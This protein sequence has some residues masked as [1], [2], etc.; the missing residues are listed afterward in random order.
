MSVELR[1]ISSPH[2]LSFSFYKSK[3]RC[4]VF[5]PSKIWWKRRVFKELC[6]Q[7]ESCSVVFGSLW[8]HGLY[9][10]WNSPGQNAGMCSC[11]L[12]QGIFPTQGL[13]PGLPHCGWILYQLSHQE[14]PRNCVKMEHI[15]QAEADDISV[16]C[17]Y[18]EMDFKRRDGS[19][20]A[21]ILKLV[22]DWK[23]YH[24]YIK[25]IW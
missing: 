12:L 18:S 23:L 10:P 6:E 9:S 14:S 21:S 16:T 17:S 7:T 8:P 22:K 20:E 1:V 15:W 19:V 3:T 4:C 13:N 25:K 11:S 24:I 5:Y 2:S